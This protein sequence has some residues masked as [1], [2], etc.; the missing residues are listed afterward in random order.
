MQAHGYGSKHVV[1][2][3]GMCAVWQGQGCIPGTSDLLV[4][5]VH[6]GL[7]EFDE[8]NYF[9]MPESG[10]GHALVLILGH[11]CGGTIASTTCVSGHTMMHT[12]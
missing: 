6:P 10:R 7:V 1:M 8:T 12:Q 2:Y 5:F 3:M 4:R 11:G 9:W